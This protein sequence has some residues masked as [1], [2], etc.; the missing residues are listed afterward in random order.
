VVGLVRLEEVALAVTIP[1]VAIGGITLD[2]VA[3]VARAGASAAAVIAAVDAA[4]DPTQAGRS[5]A[6]AFGV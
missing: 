3:A 5:L 2:N 1:V 4:P 6:S